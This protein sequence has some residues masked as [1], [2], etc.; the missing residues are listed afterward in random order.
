MNDVTSQVQ[1]AD[2]TY[3]GE[4]IKPFCLNK[5]G[6]F[7]TGRACYQLTK[8]EKI[9]DY[10]TI[11]IRDKLSGKVYEG[12][13]ARQL[14]GFPTIGDIKIAP[15]NTGNYEVF[16]QSNSVNRKL[17]AGTKVLYLNR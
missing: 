16:V 3:G 17:V 10:K 13:A 14:L 5:F 4:L 12:G 6:K 7:L 11:A 1:L 8:P 15:G 9:Q 2:V